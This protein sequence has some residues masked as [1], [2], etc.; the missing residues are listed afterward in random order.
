MK[1]QHQGYR[2]YGVAGSA[3]AFPESGEAGLRLRSTL[4]GRILGKEG[5]RK[6][7]ASVGKPRVVGVPLQM[8]TVGSL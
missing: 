6:A 4:L 1:G 3:R 8:E 5:Q 7:V 2:Y